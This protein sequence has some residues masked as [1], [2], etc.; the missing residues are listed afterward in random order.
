AAGARTRPDR[1]GARRS[2][3]RDLRHRLSDR[4]H[5]EH[6]SGGQDVRADR[7]AR[8]PRCD[9]HGAAAPPR[10]IRRALDRG[11]A[12]RLGWGA[13][14]GKNGKRAM[15]NR[16]RSIGLIALAAGG[17]AITDAAIRGA[18]A[19]SCGAMRKINIGVS[20]APPNVVHTSPHV[21]K[22]LGFFA[23]RCIEPN[24][25]QFE[26]GASATASAAAVQR[27]AIVTVSDVA[28]RLRLK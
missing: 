4:A 25:I 16:Y 21:T 14:K 26:G 24:I 22:E 13:G 23:K 1:H 20:V 9:A 2:L 12:R 6:L 7:D 5:R 3:Y 10:E 19:Q 15:S 18:A 11:I 17:V 27:S 8:P 28:T